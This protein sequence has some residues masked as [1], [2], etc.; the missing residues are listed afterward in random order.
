MN[1]NKAFLYCS[2]C[3]EEM[4]QLSFYAQSV[5]LQAYCLLNNLEVAGVS[6]DVRAGKSFGFREG[7]ES[8]L[9]RAKIEGVQ[10]S[11]I[12]EPT[13]LSRDPEEAFKALVGESL[14]SGLTLHIASWQTHTQSTEAKRWLLRMKE[15]MTQSQRLMQ[16]HALAGSST[17]SA[18]GNLANAVA[19][20]RTKP[21]WTRLFNL[22]QDERYAEHLLRA[23]FD[24][25][26]GAVLTTAET[27]AVHSGY[28][29]LHMFQALGYRIKGERTENT[30]LVADVIVRHWDKL[31]P[32]LNDELLRSIEGSETSA[33]Q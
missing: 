6:S 19:I 33:F 14:P 11:V 29:H 25:R 10:H 2:L 31:K 8:L 15:W 13:R 5:D 9:L 22:L 18:V 24:V 17:N 28:D 20:L 32:L 1:A 3:P 7:F 26:S 21:L 27:E 12:Q 30:R 23:L 4:P 16:P